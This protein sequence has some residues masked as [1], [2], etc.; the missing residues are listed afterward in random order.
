MD[1]MIPISESESARGLLNP[2]TATAVHRALRREG[3]ALLRRAFP[4]TF[5][6]RLF[7]EYYGR[8][9]GLS[10]GDMADLALAP[11]PNPVFKV[12]DL[13]FDIT[14]RIDGAF[15]DTTVFAAPIIRSFLPLILGNDTRLS[16]FTIVV[17]FPGAEL[18]HIHRDSPFLFPDSKL[19][20]EFPA[21]SII[22]TIPLVDV[23]LDTGPTGFWLGSHLWPAAQTPDLDTITR[24]PL[25]RGDCFLFDNRTLHAGLPNNG[26][27]KRPLLYMAYTRRWFFDEMNYEH[28]TPLDMPLETFWGLPETVRP[29]LLRAYSQAMRCKLMMKTNIQPTSLTPT[30]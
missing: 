17:S 28:R 25:Q 26:D 3:V 11:A 24:I 4:E 10:A 27:G 16:A 22:A 30:R 8:Y 18:Q 5:V 7:Q 21:Y 20:A 13:R 19:G 15:A 14:P 6:E 23:D 9:G 29:M 12:G 1:W 2:E